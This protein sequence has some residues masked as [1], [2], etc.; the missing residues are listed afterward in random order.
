MKKKLDDLALPGARAVS[1]G[2]DVPL[3]QGPKPSPTLTQRVAATSND[4]LGGRFAS[5]KALG[6]HSHE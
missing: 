6:E 3:R 5:K 2:F 1:D 4:L